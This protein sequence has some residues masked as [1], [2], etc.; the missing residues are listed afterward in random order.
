MTRFLMLLLLLLTTAATS[1]ADEVDE[2]IARGDSTQ[3]AMKHEKALRY[4]LEA[5]WRRWHRTR[6]KWS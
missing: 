4:Y 6:R 3:A 1:L 2:L 5:G